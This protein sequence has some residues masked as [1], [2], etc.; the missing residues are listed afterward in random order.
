[1]FNSPEDILRFNGDQ[2][3]REL[4]EVESNPG[5]AAVKEFLCY[6][7]T[8]KDYM[9]LVHHSLAA[10]TVYNE[11]IVGS[12]TGPNPDEVLEQTAIKGAGSLKEMR[13]AFD[14]FL[15]VYGF[16]ADSPNS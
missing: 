10:L 11:V 15:E 1:M 7:P 6:N 13:V 8:F 9:D 2:V 5:K 3:K 4:E 16:M 14:R 12:A